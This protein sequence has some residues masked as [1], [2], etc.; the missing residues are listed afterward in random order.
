MAFAS[1]TRVAEGGSCGAPL[2][3]CRPARRDTA[4]LDG[5]LRADGRSRLLHDYAVRHDGTESEDGIR[6]RQGVALQ[7]D[8][9]ALHARLDPVR[10]GGEADAG[11]V[12][13]SDPA[14][15]VLPPRRQIPVPP[16]R[17]DAEGVR[18]LDGAETQIERPVDVQDL[19][20]NVAGRMTRKNRRGRAARRTSTTTGRRLPDP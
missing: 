11:F 18:V 2:R 8:E 9:V 4:L 5:D 17:R 10:A 16:Q 7:D 14:R 12:H 6:I 13:L 3:A 1:L 19:K 20:V 15:Q